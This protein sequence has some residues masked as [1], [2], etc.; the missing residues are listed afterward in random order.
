MP[1]ITLY[2]KDEGIELVN[3]AKKDLGASLSSLFID[4]VRQSVN[5]PVAAPGTMEKIK[6]VLWDSN[7]DP[8]VIKSFTGCWLV[9]D[10]DSGFRSSEEGITGGTQWSVAL[11]KK[12]QLAVYRTDANGYSKPDL[13]VYESFEQFKGA[14]NSG[15]PVYPQD[16]IAEVAAAHGR[17]YEIELDI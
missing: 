10:E 2:V 3:K 4:C 16:L 13:E 7:D 5:Q 9:G 6:I 11:T 14:E 1:N 8:N 17:P 15:Y 12:E